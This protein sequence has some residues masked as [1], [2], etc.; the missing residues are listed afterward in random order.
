MDSV[1]IIV[2]GLVVSVDLGVDILRIPRLGTA[3]PA[4]IEDALALITWLSEWVVSQPDA[5][6]KGSM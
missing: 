3:K 6:N 1:A 2:D 4:S 5:F